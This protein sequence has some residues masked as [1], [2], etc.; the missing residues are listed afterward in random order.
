MSNSNSTNAKSLLG[1]MVRAT[2]Y[3]RQFKLCSQGI[4][5]ISNKVKMWV[6]DGTGT[7]CADITTDDI[8]ECFKGVSLQDIKHFTREDTNLYLE[9]LWLFDIT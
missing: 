7:P 6:K 8:L 5:K 2:A 9:Y 4:S 1:S 3:T